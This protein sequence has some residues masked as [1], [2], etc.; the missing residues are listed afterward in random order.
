MSKKR[1]RPDHISAADWAAVA[2]PPLSDAMLARLRPA[3]EVAPE[4]I[5]IAKRR[6][7]PRLAAPKEAVKI[8]LSAEVLKH[9]RAGGAGWQTRIDETLR[10]AIRKSRTAARPRH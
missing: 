2:S 7:R 3:I 9:F 6:G 5:L 1:R 10:S 8:R 4:L